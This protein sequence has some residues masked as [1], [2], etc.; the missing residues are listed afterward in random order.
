MNQPEEVPFKSLPP[1]RGGLASFFNVKE[2][3]PKFKNVA[4]NGK[5]GMAFNN[6]MLLPDNFLD[7]VKESRLRQLDGDG[8]AIIEIQSVAGEDSSA[9]LLG[10]DWDIFGFTP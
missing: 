5:I 2:P 9:D 8:L 4:N 3:S 6:P 10:L 7:L 1:K